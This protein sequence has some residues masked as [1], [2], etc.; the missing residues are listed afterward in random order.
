MTAELSQHSRDLDARIHNYQRRGMIG[1][2]LVTLVLFLVGIVVVYVMTTRLAATY[3]QLTETEQALATAKQQ[4]DQAG[5]DLA[6]VTAQKQAAD[7]ALS[8]AQAEIARL[9]DTKLQLQKEVTELNEQADNA[10]K[11][12]QQSTEYKQHL[13]PLDWTMAKELYSVSDRVAGLLEAILSYSKQGSDKP[14]KFSLA[15]DLEKGF[16]SP[17]F[18]RFILQKQAGE[19]AELSSL[20]VQTG[21]P[22]NGDI[23]RYDGGYAMFYFE[24]PYSHDNFVVGMTPLG[25][26]AVDRKFGPKELGILRSSDYFRR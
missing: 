21:A 3:R 20:P 12:V 25:I 16:T 4:L 1:T 10:V 5:Q 26:V 19:Q 15:N 13:H 17:G 23:I 2:V 8:A 18:A 7:A 6:A 24:N 22:Q 14:L 9:S 11:Q